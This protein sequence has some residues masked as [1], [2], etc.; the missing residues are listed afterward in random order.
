MIF[1]QI[2]H[3][4][5]CTYTYILAPHSGGEALIIDP[6]QDQVEHY[7]R[8]IDELDLR[9]VKAIDTHIHADHIT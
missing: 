5:S 4:E 1:R 8:V 7:L 2:F 3:H 9:L 6:V